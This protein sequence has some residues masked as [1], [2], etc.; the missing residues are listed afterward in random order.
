[1]NHAYSSPAFESAYTYTGNDLGAVWSSEKTV[2]RL[3]APTAQAAVIHLYRTGMDGTDDLLTRI[4]MVPSDNGTWLAEAPGN[5]HGVYYTYMLRFHDHT[6]ESCD[7]YARTTGVNGR[8]AMILDLASTNPDGWENDSNPNADKPITDAVIYEVSIRDLSSNVSS[9]IHHKGKFLGAAETGTHTTSLC[10]TGLDHIKNLGITHVQLMPIYDFGSVD[11]SN[12]TSKQYNWG[13]DPA[14]FN[15]PEGSYSTDPWHGEVRVREL[16]QMIRT[17]HAN[18]LSVIMD[19]VYNHVFNADDFCFN[20]IVP[21]YF[22]RPGSNGSGCGNDTASERSMVRKYIVDSVNYWA[23]EYHIDG[24]RFDLV[25]LIDI[26]TIRQV[27]DTVRAN[28]P[29][30]LFYGEGWGM[31]THVT[32]DHLDLT[33]QDNA[34]KIPDFAFFNDTLRDCLRGSLFHAGEKGYVSGNFTYKHTV[35]QCFLGKIHWA[36]NP[37]QSINYVSC[38][39][40]H[41]LFDR[42]GTALPHIPPEER[43]RRNNLAAAICMLSQGVPLMLSGEEMLRTKTGPGGRVVSNSYRSPDSVNAIKWSTLK[44]PEYQQNLAYYKGLIAFRKAFPVL[45]QATQ[46]DVQ[47]SICTLPMNKDSLIAFTAFGPDYRLYIAFNAGTEYEKLTLPKGDW[48]TYIQNEEAGVMP[49]ALR[50]ENIYISP[51]SALAL[52]QKKV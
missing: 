12:P 8:R 6:T 11:E 30:C 22:S 46:F 14:N 2:F 7:P 23:D 28:H 17:L 27:M 10:P 52:V 31:D 5:W 38:H 29:D 4:S 20:R 1:M 45:R 13:Y 16:K 35:E 44:Q 39:D 37:S 41:T 43:I 48:E 50:R 40:N 3:W 18:G 42:I 49:L 24:F 15:V 21:G 51:L 9:G 32:K 25:G 47:S 34:Q 26:Q 33:T 19:V 36:Q